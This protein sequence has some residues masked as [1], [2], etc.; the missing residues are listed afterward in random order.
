M[1]RAMRSRHYLA[2]GL[3]LGVAGVIILTMLYPATDDLYLK[4]P[5][6]NGLSKVY[7]ELEPSRIRIAKEYYMLNACNSTVLLIGPSADFDDVEVEAVRDYLLRGGRVVLCDDFGSGNQLLEKLGVETRFTG[8]LLLDPLFFDHDPCLPRLLNYTGY[9]VEKREIVLNYATTISASSGFSGMLFSSPFSYVN[10]TG[11]QKVGSYPVM[12]KIQIGKGVL[13]LLSDSSVF[14]NSMI[15][16]ADN[17]LLLRSIVNGE[18]YIDEA[19]SIPTLS[20]RIRW[21]LNDV[22]AFLRLT[23]VGLGVAALG[24]LVILLYRPLFKDEAIKLDAVEEVLKYH[25]EWNRKQLEW[26]EKVRRKQ[27]GDQ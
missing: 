19:H 15:D 21:V 10:E 14:I 18:I 24:S 7:V 13:V 4:N 11:D 20:T 8:D 23:E 9:H 27:C 16:K 5:F 12:G 2:L 26:L 1:V 22:Y 3:L 25:L 6:W 17:M